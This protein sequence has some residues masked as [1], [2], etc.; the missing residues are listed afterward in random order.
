MPRPRIGHH[1]DFD[2]RGSGGKCHCGARKPWPEDSKY[3]WCPK[4][5]GCHGTTLHIV[6]KP[7]REPREAPE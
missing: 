5:Y 7:G 3:M 6:Y 2:G 4:D 1:H